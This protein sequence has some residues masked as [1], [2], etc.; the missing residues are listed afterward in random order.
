M[1]AGEVAQQ[2]RALACS[3]RGP[4]FNTHVTE[5]TYD[6]SSEDPL[7]SYSFFGTCS[8]VHMHTDTN[9]RNFSE[10]MDSGGYL[11]RVIKKFWELLQVT[12]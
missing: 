11:F 2:L 3:T 7:L 10:K 12:G 4:E 1:N 8:H 9:E 6:T 5:F